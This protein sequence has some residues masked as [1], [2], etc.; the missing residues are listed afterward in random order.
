MPMKPV[1]KTLVCALVLDVARVSSDVS[2][3][4]PYFYHGY[5]WGSEGQF[6]PVS[7]VVN[8][9]LDIGQLRSSRGSIRLI[10]SRINVRRLNA[11][12]SHPLA[13]IDRSTGRMR[14]VETELVPT[15]MD[16]G[17]AQWVP[18]YQLHLVGG[19][20][21]NARVE[22]WYAAHGYESP[23]LAAFVTSMTAAYLNEAQE[24]EGYPDDYNTDPVAD[25]F[26]FDL[27]G[28]ALFQSTAVRE[29]FHT[30]VEWM[31][32]PLQ[33][34]IWVTDLSVRQAGQYHAFRIRNPWSEDWRPFYH[35]GLGNIG[36]ISKRLNPIDHLS[37]GAGYYALRL[38][39][40]GGGQSSVTL[41]PKL[42]VFWDRQGSLMASLFWNSQSRERLMLSL[43]PRS[44]AQVPLGWWLSYGGE[45]GVG[46]GLT[47]QT[48]F[49][50]VVPWSS[51][52]A[53]SAL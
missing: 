47:M 48:G 35:V 10:P 5:D 14:F 12:I 22:E 18:N 51:G 44:I 45:Q 43:Y 1:F 31:N 6:N 30:R 8:E 21:L 4:E 25:L 52:G 50:M 24:M 34:S 33:P 7:M 23:K 27:A 41:A 36:G 17:R 19:G 53:S 20:L 46:V 37:V 26:V 11:T 42:G 9:G 32:W 28:I 38:V 40:S 3:Q 2:A 16:K 13:S 49:G 15:S 29:F 39:P